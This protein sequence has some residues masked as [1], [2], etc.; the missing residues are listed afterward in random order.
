MNVPES[1][2]NRILHAALRIIGEHGIAGL[3]N[4]LVAKEAGLS[5]G[6]LTYHF[7]SQSELLREALLVFVT[8]ET[9][10]ITAIADSLAPTV[11]SVEE[12]AAAAE[13]AVTEMAL[14]PEE[15]GVYELYLQSARDPELHEA[16]RACFAE[17]DRAAT[18]A[19]ELLVIPGA[20]ELAPH[21]VALV[22]GAQL[23]RVA[24]GAAPTPIAAGL[25]RLVGSPSA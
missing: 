16:V 18:G 3:T 4:R 21:V 7:T 5:L 19:L 22:M 11:G 1:T 20:A 10:R 14:G 9:R 12:A 2:R 6:S 23:R 13:R 15:I 25:L 17:Y 8:E 24:T